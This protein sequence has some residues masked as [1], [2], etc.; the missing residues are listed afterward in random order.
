[1]ISVMA[2]NLTQVPED[3]DLVD[4][5]FGIRFARKDEIGIVPC[6]VCYNCLAAF[7]KVGS[8]K[9]TIKYWEMAKQIFNA[10]INGESLVELSGKLKFSDLAYFS[11]DKYDFHSA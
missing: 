7:Y 1:M 6:M 5:S 4:R 10:T 2:Q 11:L 3:T 8:K 9:T